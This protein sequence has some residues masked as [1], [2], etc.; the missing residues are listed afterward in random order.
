MNMIVNFQCQELVC[1]C[2]GMVVALCK[3]LVTTASMEE[4]NQYVP[5]VFCKMKTCIR[6]FGR[7]RE[8]CTSRGSA[9]TSLQAWL[10]SELGVCLWPC[11]KHSAH[12]LPSLKENFPSQPKITFVW[13]ASIVTLTDCIMVVAVGCSEGLRYSGQK[14][15]GQDTAVH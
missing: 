7:S 1:T 4:T 8:E 10:G 6:A 12:S 15:M 3:I 11:R 14:N 13:S 2:S 5:A 9:A